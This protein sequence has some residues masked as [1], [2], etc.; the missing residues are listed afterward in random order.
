MNHRQNAK[1][2]DATPSDLR[3]VTT[4]SPSLQCAFFLFVA[5]VSSFSG[6]GT[7]HFS[8]VLSGL[9]GCFLPDC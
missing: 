7:K 9:S 1:T 4:T 2:R 8:R 6:A 5:S 3:N